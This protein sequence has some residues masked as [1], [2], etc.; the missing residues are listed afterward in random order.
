MDGPYANIQIHVQTCTVLLHANTWL[1][2]VT[3]LQLVPLIGMALLLLHSSPLFL[4]S[5]QN[6]RTAMPL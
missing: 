3:L 6:L 4:C 5:S 1:S 2:I